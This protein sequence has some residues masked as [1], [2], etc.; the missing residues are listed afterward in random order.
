[1]KKG[2]NKTEYSCCC[3]SGNCWGWFFLIIGVWFILK[4]VNIIP[5]EITVWPVVAVVIGVYLLIKHNKK[6]C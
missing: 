5:R 4:Q 3:N 2:K 6:V 1:M